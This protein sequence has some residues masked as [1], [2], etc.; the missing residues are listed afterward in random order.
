MTLFLVLQ[1]YLGDYPD[2]LFFDEDAQKAIDT[3]QRRLS[4]ITAD[5]KKRNK[6]LQVPYHYLLPER[7]PNSIAI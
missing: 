4:E 2:Q 5:I 6:S 3:F 7:T 1:R